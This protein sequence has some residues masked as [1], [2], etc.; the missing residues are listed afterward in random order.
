MLI[1]I[2]EIFCIPSGKG[3]TRKA[4]ILMQFPPSGEGDVRKGGVRKSERDFK[5]SL[6]LRAIELAFSA[7]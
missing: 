3:E 5:H 7:E 2:P 6:G 1:Y 4:K